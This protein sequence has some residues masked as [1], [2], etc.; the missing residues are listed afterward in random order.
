MAVTP[1]IDVACALE[2]A[3]VHVNVPGRGR[4]PGGD[5]TGEC[6]DREDGEAEPHRAR[7]YSPLRQGSK[8]QTNYPRVT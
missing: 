7:G 4:R 3:L 1:R 5:R 8:T 2:I 6:H